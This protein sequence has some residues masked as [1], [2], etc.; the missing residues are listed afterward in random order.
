M[1]DRRVRTRIWAAVVF[2]LLL[3]LALTASSWA[4]DSVISSGLLELADG[5][6]PAGTSGPA[7]LASDPDQPGPDWADLFAANGAVRDLT[8]YGGVSAAF[9]ADYQSNGLFFDGDV[10][11]VGGR[12]AN[13]VAA[14][15]DDLGFSYFY[16]TLDS[17][18]NLVLYAAAER[19]GA[20][21][22]TLELEF[23]QDHFRL[24]HGGYGSAIPW[25]IDGTRHQGDV[26]VKLVFAGGAL[27]SVEASAWDGRGWNL[28]SSA[29]GT[30]CDLEET[31]CAVTNAGPIEGGPWNPQTIPAGQFVE[32]G[33]N[34]GALLD[35]ARPAFATVRLRTP[36]DASFGYFGEDK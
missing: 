1:I 3:C 26:L 35:G 31:L 13:G 29:I 10:L 20:G 22:S 15:S 34:V 19:L 24:G 17:A 11:S 33:V 2:N 23:D 32:L 28:L 5:T 30:S 21:D 9:V 16:S 6:A 25:R 8:P 27:E 36:Q 7:D 4:G 12:V 18:G 14:T